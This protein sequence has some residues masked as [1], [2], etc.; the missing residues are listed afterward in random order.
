V[1]EQ[2]APSKG[3]VHLVVGAQEREVE[4]KAGDPGEH[5]EDVGDNGNEAGDL[6]W[7]EANLAELSDAGG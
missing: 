6:G 2:G 5:D 4:C 1:E 7:G 3:L